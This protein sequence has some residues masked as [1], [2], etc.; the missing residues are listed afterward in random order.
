MVY[1]NF[2]LF[3]FITF[4]LL[5]TNKASANPCHVYEKSL[6]QEERGLSEI[7]WE[8][9]HTKPFNEVILSWNAKRSEYGRY[10]FLISLQQNGAWSPWLYYG[11]WGNLGQM[12]C[13][14]A[15][16]A[17]FAVTDR[18]ISRP[19]IGMCDGFRLKVLAPG[20][21]KFDK[22][23]TIWACLSDLTQFTSP[24]S[25]PSLE[26]ILLKN[27]PGQSLHTLRLNRHWDMSMIACALSAARYLGNID[28]DPAEFASQVMDNDYESYDFWPLNAAEAFDRLKGKYKVHIERLAD[29]SILHSYL[30]KG[31][32][33]LVNVLGT[34]FGGLP[35]PPYRSHILCVLGY[36]SVSQTVH[37]LDPIFPTNKGTL[38]S[39][40]I[41]DFLRIWAKRQNI[42]CVFEKN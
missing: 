4:E 5:C 29:F 24:P 28:I 37:C 39:Y 25:L 40:A 16:A 13:T 17:S 9:Q 33:V 10:T 18:G 3:I 21:E 34:P 23:E 36:D 12:L 20:Q 30:I 14:E 35:W 31:C 22:M 7:F 32:P 2:F 38:S 6:Q 19:K 41:D 26:T 42:A 27:V 11:D 8:V 1:K 15:P